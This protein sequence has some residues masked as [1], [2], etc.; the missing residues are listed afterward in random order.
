MVQGEI[1]QGLAYLEAGQRANSAFP[2][3]TADIQLIIERA[4]AQTSE[5]AG[6]TSA[7]HLLLGS[8]LKTI[9]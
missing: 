5:D 2:P 8:Y 4:R 1:E 3:L 7:E 6:L 9:N